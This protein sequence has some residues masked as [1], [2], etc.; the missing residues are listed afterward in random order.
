MP[1]RSI[2]KETIIS[3]VR[4]KRGSVKILKCENSYVLETKFYF[5]GLLYRSTRKTFDSVEEAE[6][7]YGKVESKLYRRS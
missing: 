6:I 3:G 5:L 4:Y 2:D 1:N 7:A